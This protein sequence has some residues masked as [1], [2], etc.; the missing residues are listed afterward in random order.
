MMTPM[1]LWVLNSNEVYGLALD[2]IFPNVTPSSFLLSLLQSHNLIMHGH[3]PFF[4]DI[5]HSA[6][7]LKVSTAWNPLPNHLLSVACSLSTS[8]SH[9]Y[10]SLLMITIIIAIDWLISQVWHVDFMLIFSSL[11]VTTFGGN[12]YFF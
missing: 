10:Y 11:Y 12:S 1:G 3:L 4:Q 7:F 8:L 5:Q 9:F 2:L 6:P